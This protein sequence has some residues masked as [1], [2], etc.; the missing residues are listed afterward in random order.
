VGRFRQLG[1]RRGLAKGL[2]LLGRL[3]A[4]R[5]DDAA[6]GTAYTECLELRESLGKVDL[7][8]VVEGLAEVF[9]RIMARTAAPEELRRA[10]RL[11]G[12]AA[13]LRDRLG[14]A[15][16]RSWANPVASLHRE[17]REHHVSALRTALGEEAFVLVWADAWQLPLE[18]TI[19]DVLA[20]VPVASGV[21]ARG[22]VSTY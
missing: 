20:V 3:Y 13:S 18:Q 16:T 12:A 6:A 9:G 22:P 17:E 4:V 10:V 8:F 2:A 1:D 7:V 5:G 21:D 15:A 11:F 19:T 14:T